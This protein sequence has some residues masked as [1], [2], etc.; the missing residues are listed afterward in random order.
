MFDELDR[1]VFAAGQLIFQHGD[2]GDCAYLIEKG[3]VEVFV[4][5]QGA[6]RRIKLLGKDELFGEVSLIDH[7][8]RTATVRAIDETVLVPIPRKLVEELLERSDPILRHL[9]MV[10]LDRFRHRQWSVAEQS[11]GATMSHEQSIRRNAVKGVATQRLS[12]AHGMQRAL[13]R[14]EFQM[15]YQPICDLADGHVAGFEALIRWVHPVDGL[16]LP[17]DFVWVAE[18]TGII[19]EIG[20]WTLERACLDWPMLRR[21]TNHQT[22]FVS[23]NLSAAQISNELLAQDVQ[24]ILSSQNMNPTELKLELTET[25][26]VEQPEAALKVL[27]RLVELGCGLALDDYGAGHSSL[28]RLQR[29]P[30]GT[31]KIDHTFIAPILESAQSLEIVR[32]SIALAHSLGMDVVA[33]G[34]ESEAVR[35]KLVEIGCDFGQGWH[36]GRPAPL[37]ELMQRYSQP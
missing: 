31:L 32:S 22:P 35:A 36:L 30:L 14:E 29:Y 19:R 10:I 2:W 28:S 25:V 20:L 23:V 17:K 27:E 6:E 1:E 34:I 8:P 16:M 15:Y 37:A 26:M 13:L 21:F 3:V 11:S 9:L 18:Q 24:T 5:V 33:E 12:L 7:Q 4:V